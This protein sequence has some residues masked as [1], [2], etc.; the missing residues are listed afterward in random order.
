MIYF[1]GAVDS[2]K[3]KIPFRSENILN[4]SEIMKKFDQNRRHLNLMLG[5]LID[6]GSISTMLESFSLVQNLKKKEIFYSLE[7]SILHIFHIIFIG[8]ITHKH[9]RFQIFDSIRVLINR[10]EWPEDLKL[11]LNQK[12]WNEM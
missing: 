11:L 7:E 5:F 10:L 6:S 3:V 12:K 1:S 4:S 8:Q 9:E 2:L